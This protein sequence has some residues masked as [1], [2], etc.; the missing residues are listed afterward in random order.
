[1]L[2][3]RQ[4]VKD[5]K[6]NKK[7]L[8]ALNRPKPFECVRQ[9]LTLKWDRQTQ[10]LS[11]KRDRE[12]TFDPSFFE[13]PIFP[14]KPQQRGQWVFEIFLLKTQPLLLPDDVDLWDHLRPKPGFCLDENFLEFAPKLVPQ[15]GGWRHPPI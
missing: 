11:L 9:S 3:Y 10:S 13:T 5:S 14:E 6:V 4:C 8:F 12:T 7:W 1:M 2:S 15:S